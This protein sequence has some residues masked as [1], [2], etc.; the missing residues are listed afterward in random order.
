[1]GIFRGVWSGRE[2]SQGIF[3]GIVGFYQRPV[4]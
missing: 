4:G 1:M 3:L 2:E